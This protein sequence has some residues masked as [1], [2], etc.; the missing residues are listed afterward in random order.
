MKC[1]NSIT[2]LN[3]PSITKAAYDH[4]D[5]IPGNY[6]KRKAGE[7]NADENQTL[8]YKLTR[9]L[10]ELFEQKELNDLIRDLN[11]SKNKAEILVSRHYTAELPE[12]ES[13][14]VTKDSH[15]HLDFFPEYLGVVSHEHGER[16]YQDIAEIEKRY[17]G[18]WSVNALAE[19]TPK[20][21]ALGNSCG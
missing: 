7:I 19:F 9:K 21:D 12:N 2:Y 14:H 10:L 20:P 3:V 11:L 13:E 8:E 6:A 4:N 17:Q 16:F 1:K 18:K 5:F 15:S